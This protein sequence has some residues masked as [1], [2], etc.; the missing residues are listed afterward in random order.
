MQVQKVSRLLN[1]KTLLKGLEKISEHGASFAAG[2]SLVMSLGVRPL[3]I[4]P[5]R[6]WKKKISNMQRQIQF[7]QD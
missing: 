2:T 1:N 4:F 7:A 3:A 6:M 5:L